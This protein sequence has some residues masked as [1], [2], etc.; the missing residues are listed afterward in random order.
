MTTTGHADVLIV[1]AGL[2]GI[3]AAH[4]IQ[5]AFPDRTYTILEARD[6]IGGTWDLFRYPGVRSDSDMH[7]LG[8]RFR[9]WTQTRAIADGASIL[10]YIRDTA[11]EAGIDRHIRFGHRVVRAAWSTEDARWT[12]DAVHD[13]Q[14]VRLT[15]KFLYVCSGYYRYDAGHTPHVPGADRFGGTIVHPQHWPADLDYDGKKVVVI[16]S[17]ATAVTLVPAMTD[18]A[19]HVTMLQRSPTYVASRPA[20]DPIANRLRRLLGVRRAYP[21]TRWKNVVLGALFYQLSR[22]RPEVMKSM[23]R[24]AAIQQLPLGYDIDTHFTPRYQPWDQRLCF[25]PD[26]DLFAAIRHGRASVVTD[27][28]REFTETGLR[29]ESGAELEADIVITATGL[30]MLALGGIQLTVD[31]RDITLPET[32]AYKSMMLSGVPNFAFTIGYTNASWTLKADLVSGYVVRLL[33]YLDAHGYDQCVPTNND[34]S[35]TQRPLLDFQAGYVLRSIDEFP[36]AGSRPP[37]RL[38]MSYAHDVLALRYGRIDE[39]VL[40]CQCR[41]DR[42]SGPLFVTNV[43][44]GLARGSGNSKVGRSSPSS[45][46]KPA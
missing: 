1:G 14:P 43:D 33:R 38:G 42:G 2:S 34:P 21:I 31:G 40:R 15:T 17:G 25:A 30:R 22:R 37:W 8:Y 29:L 39:G 24:K 32:M 28:I 36:K 3:G 19:A 45:L 12:V 6:A 10:R 5:S 27:H 7:T 41:P 9:P 16:G 44:P 13:G 20:E 4:H 11:A 46:K 35:L 26:G 18:R 23:I